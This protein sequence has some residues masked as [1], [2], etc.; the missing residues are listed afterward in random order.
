MRSETPHKSVKT[1]AA[2]PEPAVPYL[3]SSLPVLLERPG[4][5]SSLRL[6]PREGW[7]EVELRS[8]PPQPSP[9]P[10]PPT[11]APPSPA[12]PTPPNGATTPRYIVPVPNRPQSA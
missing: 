10:P 8:A 2:P 4:D 5:G 6:S 12:A 11:K 3:L 9:S 7:G 1:T